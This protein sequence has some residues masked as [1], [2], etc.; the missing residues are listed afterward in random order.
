[1]SQVIRIAGNNFRINGDDLYAR[2]LGEQFD[3]DLVSVIAV[4]CDDGCN[5]LDVGGNIGLTA[6][7]LSQ[8]V[9]SGKVVAVEPVPRTFNILSSNVSGMENV[10]TRNFAFGKVSGTLPMQGYEDNLSG[11]FIADAFHINDSNHFTVDVPVK[12]IDESFA[13]LGLESL[14]FMKIDVEGFELDVLEGGIETLNRFK[15]RVVLEMNHWCLNMFR[16][17]SIPEFRERLAAIFPYIYAVEGAEYLDFA[18][19]DTAYSIS[20]RHIIEGKFSN[21][22]AGF[23]RSDL[24]KRLASLDRARH[25]INAANNSARTPIEDEALLAAKDRAESLERQLHE[26]TRQLQELNSRIHSDQN[27]IRHATRA[28]EILQAERDALKQ[29]NAALVGSTSWRVTAPIRAIKKIIS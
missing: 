14:D 24:I 19:V 29:H 16:R 12:T 27:L 18:N 4:L 2:S 9:G 8:I 20:H 11:S 28:Q 3:P 22:V 1:M 15:P 6:L 26:S 5:A 13:T 25:A 7:A 23:D 17:I 21:I 10:S